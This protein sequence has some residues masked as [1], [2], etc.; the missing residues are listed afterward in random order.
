VAGGRGGLR[1]GTVKL[2]LL[3]AD[4][5]PKVGNDRRI[6]DPIQ[7]LQALSMCS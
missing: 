4:G 2:S 1:E 7:L 6:G 3:G 5:G